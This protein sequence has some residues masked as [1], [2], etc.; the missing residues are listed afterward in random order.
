MPPTLA[1]L[2]ASQLSLASAM[3]QPPAPA[4]A[5]QR[6]WTQ[7]RALGALRPDFP[8]AAQAA[9]HFGD[10]TLRFVVTEQGQ[11]RD[12]QVLQST[13]SALLDAAGRRAV[14]AQAFDPARDE[15]GEPLAGRVQI[16]MAFLPEEPSCREFL[17]MHAWWSAT[18]PERPM[19]ETRA[20]R[21]EVP[22]AMAQQQAPGLPL[23]EARARALATALTR[24]RASAEPQREYLINFFHSAPA[25]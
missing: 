2:L 3:A 25:R 23:A 1:L 17:Q 22:D 10:L 9:G 5:P 20:W 21:R 7:P 8:P 12:V 16:S 18:W 14:E 24:C 19:T 15:A 6:A 13:G 4:S 11:V